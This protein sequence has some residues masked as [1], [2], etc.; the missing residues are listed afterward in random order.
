MEKYKAKTP[1]SW[2]C[3]M[4]AWRL[5]L[6]VTLL[7]NVRVTTIGNRN[8]VKSEIISSSRIEKEEELHLF[9]RETKLD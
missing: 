1:P 3:W 7:I 5:S 9:R 6:Y 8:T 2:K 4:S